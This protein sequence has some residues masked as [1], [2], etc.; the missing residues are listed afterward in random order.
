MNNMEK[1]YSVRDIKYG[2]VAVDL[3][4][5]G[6]MK[7][8]LHFC[9]YWNEPGENE[10]Y[11]L[12]EELRTNETFGLTEIADRLTIMAAPDDLVQEYVKQLTEHEKNNNN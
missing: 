3:T 4:Q 8:V 1:E 5:E 12:L 6:D 7:T 11:S 9:G 2:L 10:G